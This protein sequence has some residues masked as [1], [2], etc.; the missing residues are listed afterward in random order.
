MKLN[1]DLPVS[2]DRRKEYEESVE[3]LKLH[4]MGPEL[5]KVEAYLRIEIA[6][7]EREANV[8]WLR[9]KQA[10][11]FAGWN[12]AESDANG[13][14]DIETAPKDGTAFLAWCDAREGEI[15]GTVERRFYAVLSGKPSTSDRSA[16]PVW[17]PGD[18]DAYAVWIRATHW[19]PLKPP[20]DCVRAM[21]DR[22]RQEWCMNM[23]RREGDAAIG[24]GCRTES[25]LKPCPF[26]GGEASRNTYETESLWSHNIVTYTQVGC[27]ECDIHFASEPGFEVEA[28]A[29]WNLMSNIE[30]TQADREAAEEYLQSLHDEWHANIGDDYIRAQRIALGYADD[31]PLV[32]AFARHRIAAERRD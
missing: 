13:W 5:D 10:E 19:M 6:K 18:G 24:A 14:M 22:E 16:D 15:T 7:Q 1:G 12:D 27:D 4:G 8:A 31:D 29:A 30:I 17:W 28:P 11:A 20:P 21:S 23:A 9:S 32:Q 25:D 26:C 3:R 2:D